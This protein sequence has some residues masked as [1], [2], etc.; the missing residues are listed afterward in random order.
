MIIKKTEI[1]IYPDAAISEELLLP[2]FSK[3]IIAKAAK[4][5]AT[6]KSTTRKVAGKKVYNIVIV[7][8]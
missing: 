5:R 6:K 3:R 2:F 1:F 4:K 8:I 7:G